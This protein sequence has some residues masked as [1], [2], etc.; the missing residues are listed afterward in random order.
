MADGADYHDRAFDA[1]SRVG[2]LRSTADDIDMARWFAGLVDVLAAA[3]KT[4]VDDDRQNRRCA[5]P[6]VDLD[7]VRAML[8]S[9]PASMFLS[10]AAWKKQAADAI[11]LLL[12]LVDWQANAVHDLKEEGTAYQYSLADG[13]RLQNELAASFPGNCSHQHRYWRPLEGTAAGAMAFAADPG[14]H[15]VCAVCQDVENERERIAAWCDDA[16]A[17]FAEWSS[18]RSGWQDMARALRCKVSSS[19]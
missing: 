8:D 7:S 18:D 2:A 14:K 13:K 19:R 16:A 17:S 12:S 1:I 6:G 5:P 11:K 3:F 15:G 4:A 10:D 9:M